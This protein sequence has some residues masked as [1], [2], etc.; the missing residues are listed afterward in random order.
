[1]LY[2]RACDECGRSEE[3]VM[4]MADGLAGKV[5]VMCK[6]GGF[7]LQRFTQVNLTPDCVPTRTLDSKRAPKLEG[8]NLGKEQLTSKHLGLTNEQCDRLKLKKNK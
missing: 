6:C 4:P 2:Q 7:L 3:V 8:I 5:D 1:M